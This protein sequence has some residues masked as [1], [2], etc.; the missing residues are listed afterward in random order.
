[1]VVLQTSTAI[2]SIY[3]GMIRHTTYIVIE[4][5]YWQMYV[6]IIRDVSL[7]SFKLNTR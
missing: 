5:L 2:I 3:F 4:R 7:K 1:M 6:F